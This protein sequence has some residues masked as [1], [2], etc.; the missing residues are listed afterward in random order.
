MHLV[1]ISRL[2]HRDRYLDS[3]V[4]KPSLLQ[5]TCML[6]SLPRPAL[7]TGPSH[8]SS[9]S[10]PIPAPLW[11]HLGS[12][13]SRGPVPLAWGTALRTFAVPSGG[14]GVLAAGRCLGGQPGHTAVWESEGGGGVGVGLACPAKSVGPQARICDGGILDR[15]PGAPDPGATHS[16]LP[17]ASHHL[18]SQV[19][20]G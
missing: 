6:L 8:F 20:I 5:Q 11:L 2:F 14:R 17:P 7:T 9:S 19:L 4:P 13:S 10:S 12:Q 1:P 16:Q 3:S 15:L 18:W